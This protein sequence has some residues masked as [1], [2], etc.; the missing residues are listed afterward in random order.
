M[1]VDI[2]DTTT[3]QRL[4]AAGNNLLEYESVAGTMIELTASS[5]TISTDNQLSMYEGFS[6]V[7]VINGANLKVA[8]FI[9]TRL[10]LSTPLTATSVTPVKGDIINQ[11]TTKSMVIDYVSP[12]VSSIYGYTTTTVDFTDGIISS[13]NL[14]ISI[15]MVTEVFLGMP[16]PKDSAVNSVPHWYDFA[17]YPGTGVHSAVTYGAMPTKAYLGCLY[18]GRCVVAGD[19]AYPHQWYMA[20]QA[21]P[22]DWAYA[23]DDAQSPV[24]G[25]NADA[26]EVGDIIRALI[27]YKDDY[28]VFGCATSMWVL[29]G[30]A[31]AGGSLDEIS[32]TIGIF[33]SRSWCFDG[34]DNLYFWGTG[35]VYMIPPGFGPP[36]N[37]SSVRLPDLIGDEAADPSTHRISMVYD[38]KRL[39]LLVCITVLADGSNSNY[40]LDLR[41][42]GFFPETYPNTCGAYSSFYYA[43]NDTDF[44]DLLMGCKDGH[45]RKFSDSDKEDHETTPHKLIDSY[46]SLAPIPLS[47]DADKEGKMK[48]LSITT[49][50]DTDSIDV[51]LWGKDTAETLISVM[52]VVSLP[53]HSVTLSS[54]G[55]VQRLR[56]RTRGTYLGVR[57]QNDTAL[58]AVSIGETWSFEKIV[59]DIGPAGRI[60]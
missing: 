35:G 7:F 54:G 18:R 55:R 45:I 49:G 40:W 36:Q 59:A 8:D 42:G 26:G 57:L 5:G 23:A 48:S 25:N 13:Q 44:A 50:I 16:G 56:L 1:A 15:A 12:N 31:T 41:T 6:K 34:E 28:L 10:V 60:K 29:R 22:W 32:L 3:I 33:G 52:V 11:G 2:T 37:I 20:R 4:I 14:A 39:G 30:D 51:E 27:P 17:P 53:L 24:A 58:T 43:A 46:V 9:N 38:R 19:P 47:E 21:N